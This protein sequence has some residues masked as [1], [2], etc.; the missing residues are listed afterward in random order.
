[1]TSE[2][3]IKIQKMRLDKKSYSKIAE[4]L[5]VPESTVKSFFRR[6]KDQ[7]NNK[8][9]VCKNCKKKLEIIKKSKPKTFCCDNCRINFWRKNRKRCGMND[10][11][12]RAI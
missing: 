12:T 11:K 1:V 9:T 3:K 2:E 6:I 7:N 8:N 4:A 5:K 10:I